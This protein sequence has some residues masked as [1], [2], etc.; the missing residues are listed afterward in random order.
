MPDDNNM[1]SS[2]TLEFLRVINASHQGPADQDAGDAQR[3][4]SG[5][6]DMFATSAFTHIPTDE[7]Q[8]PDDNYKTSAFIMP[9]D[10]VVEPVEEPKPIV[11]KGGPRRVVRAD[12]Q[13]PNLSYAL[14]QCHFAFASGREMFAPKPPRHLL[15][16]TLIAIVCLLAVAAIFAVTLNVS[17]ASIDREEAEAY[18]GTDDYDG[19][20]SLTPADDGGYYTVF[21]VTSTP[22]DEKEIGE[23]SQVVLYRYNRDKTE[24]LRIMIPA[25]IYIEPTASSESYTLQEVL[26]ERGIDGAL[27][28]LMDS[29][30]IRLYNVVCTDQ[31]TYDELTRVMTGE[32]SAASIDTEELI[33]TMRTNMTLEDLVALCASLGALDQSQVGGF[34]IPATP[35]TVRGEQLGECT[36]DLYHTALVRYLSIPVN[37]KYDVNGYLMGTQYTEDG[38]PILD[39]YGTP[40]D[41]VILEDGSL[42][43][44][45]EGYLQFYYDDYESSLWEND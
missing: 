44:N 26:Q 30:G 11:I 27:S 29:L 37:A 28:G 16:N 6:D 34:S 20:L 2:D 23:L 22:T 19:E 24:A 10:Y 25:T 7:V 9:D 45:S 12:G 17:L 4:E 33:G 35:I 32:A 1:H 38:I 18:I 31:T 21:F 39:E 40:M 36:P 41:A 3:N 15:R 43:F 5:S 13:R 8:D 14:G 42:L